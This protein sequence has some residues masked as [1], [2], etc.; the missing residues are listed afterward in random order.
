MAKQF[1]IVLLLIL[2]CLLLIEGRI[3]VP[4]VEGVEVRAIEIPPGGLP[5]SLV[6]N[7]RQ[8]FSN[9][10]HIGVTAR[11]DNDSHNVAVVHW[12]GYP[13]EVSRFLLFNITWFFVMVGDIR[14]YKKN[15]RWTVWSYHRKLL[16]EVCCLMCRHVPKHLVQY[17]LIC[18]QCLYMAL[19][20]CN[21]RCKF[22]TYTKL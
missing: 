17:E 13:S 11:L 4:K 14:S 19:V 2:T 21:L 6:R 1:R 8:D 5:L 18:V 7:K 20:G 3:S 16:M 22:D 9:A 12:S 15:R 10:S